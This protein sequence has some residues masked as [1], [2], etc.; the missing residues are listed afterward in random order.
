M[1]YI[2]IM[3]ERCFQKK[4]LELSREA[5]VRAQEEGLCLCVSS[6]PHVQTAIAAKGKG[7]RTVQRSYLAGNVALARGR[8]S[9]ASTAS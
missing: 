7:G 8:E 3:K 1:S 2:S 5:T 9:N 4:A 6:E